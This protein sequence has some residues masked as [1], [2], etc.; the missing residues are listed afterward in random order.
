MEA[1]DPKK[2]ECVGFF[3][4]GSGYFARESAT[5]GLL[6]GAGR[7]E[8]CGDCPVKARCEK[9][10]VRRVRQ[11]RQEEVIEFDREV[12]EG[13][14]RGLTPLLVSIGR[15]KAGRPDPFMATALE[16]FQR[17]MGDR[18]ALFDRAATG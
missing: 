5:A 10:H 2:A 18:G 11:M 17:G 16:N 3:L 14:K 8:F 1:M 15:Y 12:R 7:S 6:L 13:K 4:Y 9:Q